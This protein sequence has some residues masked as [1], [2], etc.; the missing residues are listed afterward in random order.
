MSCKKLIMFLD[1]MALLKSYPKTPPITVNANYVNV[2]LGQLRKPHPRSLEL[3]AQKQSAFYRTHRCLS[4]NL[5]QLYSLSTEK[6]VL[7]SQNRIHFNDCG[8]RLNNLTGSDNLDFAKLNSDLKRQASSLQF[9]NA[10]YQSFI[11]IH[12]CVPCKLTN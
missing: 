11:F 6:D 10:G 2:I 12:L 9:S 7:V 1:E 4:D 5:L 3:G 8:S